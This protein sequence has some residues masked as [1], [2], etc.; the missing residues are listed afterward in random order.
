M[1]SQDGLVRNGKEEP[2][3]TWHKLAIALGAVGLA[4]IVFP[5][6]LWFRRA[7]FPQP[8]GRGVLG[9][10]DHPELAITHLSRGHKRLIV[11]AHGLLRSM[12]DHNMIAMAQALAEHFDVITFDFPGH[13]ASAGVS[14]ASFASAAQ[15]LRRVIDHGHGLSYQRVGVIGYSMGA[16]AAILAAAEGAPVDAVVSVSCPGSLPRAATTKGQFATWPWRWWARLMGTRLAP[17]LELGPLPIERVGRVSPI[18][19]LIVHCGL[20]TLVRREDSET[21]FAVARPPKDYL[22]VPSALHA[23]P[24]SFTAQIIAWLEKKMPTAA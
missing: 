2:L 8:Y 24:M 20:D 3:K 5:R 12:S 22:F 10:E 14:T 21:L 18:P 7:R 4:G 13:G 11:A 9:A 19:L 16:A 6:Y 15:D 17:K 1:S 23:M